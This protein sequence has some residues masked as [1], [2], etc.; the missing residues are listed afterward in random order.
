M[1]RTSSRII[2][3]TKDIPFS[4]TCQNCDAGMGIASREQAH[5]EGWTGIV[6]DDGP[7]WNFVGMCPECYF[8]ERGRRPPRRPRRK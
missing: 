1:P 4:L 7:S 2:V 8:E 6:Y 5:A 3:A